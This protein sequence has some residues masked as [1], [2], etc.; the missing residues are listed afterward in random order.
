MFGRNLSGLVN[1]RIFLESTAATP[2]DCSKG[3]LSGV[4]RSRRNILTIVNERFDHSTHGVVPE[5]KRNNYYF[6]GDDEPD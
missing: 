2:F 5:G 1:S 4:E 3:G 6:G